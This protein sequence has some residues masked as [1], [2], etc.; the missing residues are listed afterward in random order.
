MKIFHF[1]D[2]ILS[3]PQSNNQ[4]LPPLH[5][6]IKPTNVCNHNCSYCAYRCD[7]MQLGKDMNNTDYIPEKKMDEIIDDFKDIGV[8]AIT[9]SGGG[10]PF[11]YPYLLNTSKKLI[12]TD[13]KFAAL[14]NGSQLK[15]EIAKIFSKHAT[16]IR[17][18]IDGWDDES[19]S[20]YRKVPK[21]EFTKIINN[22]INFINL[23]G[24]CYL[25]V[26]IIV[27]K[28]NADHLF[29]LLKLFY[30]IGVNSIKISPCIVSNDPH[31]NNAYHKPIFKK[32][33]DTILR[34]M[35]AFCHKP[36]FQ[37]YDSYHEIDQ[38]F[39]KNYEW[40]PYL[41]VLPVIGADLNI[42]SCQD[43]A[44]NLSSG[45]IGSIKEISFKE[46]WFSNKNNFFKINPSNDCNHHCIS[47][48]KNKMLLEYLNSDN[49]HL[50]FV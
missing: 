30:D 26:S 37:L 35:E 36:S 25:G 17:I 19:Y 24:K 31:S 39:E 21:G 20:L 38:Q 27:D 32:V 29:D 5:V 46:F 12:N 16:W 22:I 43:K 2:K 50:S 7:H 34:S 48:S 47:N 13:I 28:L 11:C 40:C 44:Y 1:T 9:F 42:Y 23:N 33:K 18:S 10:D 41:Q 14:T 15:G 49:D 4:I 3:L 45:I 6:R 8:K